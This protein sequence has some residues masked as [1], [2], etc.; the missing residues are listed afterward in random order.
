MKPVYIRGQWYASYYWGP[1][2]AGFGMVLFV[3]LKI[4]RKN[5][6]QFPWE[7]LLAAIIAYHIVIGIW[8]LMVL[9]KRVTLLDLGEE[10]F[11]LKD[12]SGE[13]TYRDE[14][15]LALSYT[16]DRYIVNGQDKGYIHKGEI[17]LGSDDGLARIPFDVRMEFNKPDYLNAFLDR[18]LKRLLNEAEAKLEA[19]QTLPGVGWNLSPQGIVLPAKSEEETD[20]ILKFSQIAAI[21]N[22]DG[23]YLIYEHGRERP[24][25][26][27]PTDT[28]NAQPLAVIIQAKVVENSAAGEKP[29][30]VKETFGEGS[31]EAPAAIGTLGRYLGQHEFRNNIGYALAIVFQIV[32]MLG[33]IALVVAGIQKG[34]EV[35]IGVGGVSFLLG[36]AWFFVTL[37]R[38]KNKLSVF[39]RGVRLERGKQISECRYDE[40][41]GLNWS[42][43]AHYHNGAFTGNV[44]DIRLM[45]AD[46]KAKP[47]KIKFSSSKPIPALELMENLCV[48]EMLPKFLA[49]F[50]AGQVVPWAD[51]VEFRPEGLYCPKVPTGLL[52][53]EPRVIPYVEIVYSTLEAGYIKVYTDQKKP[54]ASIFLNRPNARV[55]SAIMSIILERQQSANMNPGERDG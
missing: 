36:L 46:A 37:K 33:G 44:F 13:A 43:V 48:A 11:L 50:D 7:W 18:N 41:E 5:Q 23:K 42:V 16:Q 24:S 31:A 6:A 20:T 17:L 12:R 14:Q 52:K 30:Q 47:M 4:T 39:E 35:A 19:G 32:L 3:F 1:L 8:Y 34:A 26:E 49:R 2:V 28:L 45:K 9:R 10:G 38:P 40:I 53:S 21:S 54:V 25:L 27:V 51:K 29:L 15:I 22:I 55:G